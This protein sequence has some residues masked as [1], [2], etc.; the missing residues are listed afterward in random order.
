MEK[1]IEDFIEY[2]TK[3]KKASINTIQSY[4]RDL[5]KMSMFMEEHGINEPGRI[6]VTNINAYILYLEKKGLSTATI[7]RNIASMKTYFHYLM[8]NKLIDYEPVEFLKAPAI[9]KKNPVILTISEVDRLLSQPCGNSSKEVRD[10]AMIEL[11]YAT[12][13]RVTELINLRIEDVNL[14][15]NYILCHSNTKKD[16]VVPFGK[17]AKK[18]IQIYL[19]EY[20]KEFIKGDDCQYLFLNCQG[21]QMSRQGF[22]KIIKSYGEM[23]GINAE[24]TP[25]VIRHS[26]AAH[27]VANG[28]DLKSVQEMMGHSDIASTQVYADIAQQKIRN[29]YERTHPRR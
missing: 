8:N 28:A 19:D 21:N 2:I 12:G 11:L 16:R 23:A 3:V 5:V 20:R 29:V 13:I 27:L 14:Q 6:T 10:R 9:E 18:S 15:M 26:F 7:S 25:H 17:T 4:R 1:S 22:W 24:I